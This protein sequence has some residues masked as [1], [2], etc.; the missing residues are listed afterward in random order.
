[1]A[2]AA[3]AAPGPSAAPSG[4][5]Q[6][7][8]CPQCGDFWRVGSLFV[9]DSCGHRKCRCC[10]IVEGNECGTCNLRAEA[11]GSAGGSPPAEP[12]PATSAK[13]TAGG[14]AALATC[15]S[16]ANTTGT[17]SGQSPVPET[18]ASSTQPGD[19]TVKTSP[20][21][22]T[23]SNNKKKDLPQQN[24]GK[25]VL[26]E[27]NVTN[28]N[29]VRELTWE[30]GADAE[31][32]DDPDPL[33]EGGRPAAKRPPPPTHSVIKLPGQLHRE[34]SLIWLFHDAHIAFR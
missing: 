17:T 9:R 27:L 31:A 4:R 6:P 1:M 30:D 14:P 18:P 8:A 13:E 2:A 26:D 11:G 29:N 34:T 28:A 10:V 32:V 7:V 20:S 24:S 5:A 15:N 12:S 23:A 21:S 33:P 3:V 16:E 22:V 19:S 25:K